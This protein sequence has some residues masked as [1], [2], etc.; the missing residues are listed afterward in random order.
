MALNVLA[1][2]QTRLGP[3]GQ[4]QLIYISATQLKLIPRDGNLIKIGGQL[5]QIP[6]AGIT[7]TNASFG[8]AANS[9]IYFYASVSGGE[10]VLGA[11]TTAHTTDTTAGN[12]GTEI[13]SGDNTKSLVGMAYS[14]A[15]GQF[16]NS[17]TRRLVRSW[18]NDPGVQFFNS[19]ASSVSTTN[20]AWT[21]LDAALRIQALGW[22]GEQFDV[23][24]TCMCSNSGAGNTTYLMG[25]VDG[26]GFGQ[27]G[28]MHAA[29][30]GYY[31]TISLPAGS[32]FG[33]DVVRT[34]SLAG[35]V[36]G[37]TGY[38]SNKMI[39]GATLGR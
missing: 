5:Y 26:G 34:F 24:F 3:I 8:A 6:A 33:T 1:L 15:S 31:T 19:V 11:Y 2:A 35:Q 14:N 25:W 30:N 20:T 16:E 37:G 18:Y 38:F 36:G 28:F 10:V 29:A 39:S 7:I 27:Y 4:C 32:I 22:A 21:E 17:A 12:V 13:M 9:R 23:E